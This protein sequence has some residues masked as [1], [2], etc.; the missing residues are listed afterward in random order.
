MRPPAP[1]D[2]STPA[3]KVCGKTNHITDNCFRLQ[4]GGYKRP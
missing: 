2:G 1:T 4:A 3:C